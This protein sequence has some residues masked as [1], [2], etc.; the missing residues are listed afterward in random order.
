MRQPFDQIGA[1]I[2]FRALGTVRLIGAAMK[3]QQLPAGDHHALVERERKLVG[4]GRRANR[5]PRHQKGVERLVV[6]I[7]DIGEVIVGKGRV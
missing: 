5:L 7:A 3:E 1:A 6:L 4:A 2:L